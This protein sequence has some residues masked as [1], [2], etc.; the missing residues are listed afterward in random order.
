MSMLKRLN[1]ERIP[2]E[3][4]RRPQ[5]VVWRLE[6]RNGKATKVPYNPRTGRKASSTD[7]LTW[8]TF[9][10]ALE[11][12]DRF[13][14]VGFVFSSGDPYTG[15]DLDGCVD[16]ETGEVEPWAAEIAAELDSY[17]EI[18]PSGTGVH[19]I[20]RGRLPEGRRRKGRVEMYDQG[21]FF[22]VTGHVLG[23]AR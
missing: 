11:V 19:I 9:E 5:W 8:G 1:S 2:D 22:T 4:K 14:G 6:E 20:A 16:P 18:S 12:L 17:T 7:S 21:R 3:M 13:D 23:G 10:D 15:V